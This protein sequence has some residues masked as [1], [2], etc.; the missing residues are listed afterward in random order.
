VAAGELP[1]DVRYWLGVLPVRRWVNRRMTGDPDKLYIQH[2]LESLRARWPL[3]RALSIGCGGGDL[4]RGV[5][6]LGAVA[7]IEGSDVGEG[8]IR[9]A[10]EAAAR[11]GLADRVKYTVSDAA[12]HLERLLAA[13]ERFDLVFFHGVLHHLADLEVVIDRAARLLRE[14]PRGLIY[15]DEYIGPS[16]V[17]WTPEDLGWASGLFARV[18]ER[19][20]RTPQVLPPIAMEDPTE[21]IRSDEIERV[22][23]ERLEVVEWTPYY[24][25]VLNPL[26]CSIRG[27]A[28]EEPEVA[29]VLEDAM[30]L[31][32]WLIDRRLLTPLYAACVARAKAS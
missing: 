6:G 26:V 4:E 19:F 12:S 18:P 25:N 1:D 24:G 2:F 23:R 21:M 15:I 7:A 8:S 17:H 14:S 29:R 13:G 3:P 28:L 32:D 20:R 31:E 10:R 22:V 27:S 9:I 5:V 11:E 30:A 16:R